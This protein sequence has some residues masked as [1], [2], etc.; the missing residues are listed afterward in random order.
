MP[1][2]IPPPSREW[3]ANEWLLPPRGKGRGSPGI[4]AEL[5]VSKR[6]VLG[7]LKFY[8]ITEPANV[9]RSAHRK[10]KATWSKDDERPDKEELAKLYLMPPDGKGKTLEWLTRHY[11]VSIVTIRKWLNYYDLTQPFHLR[12][13]KR[14]AGK[15][16]S[17]YV[18]GTSRAYHKRT[19]SKSGRPKECAWCKTTRRV[20]VH[21]IDHDTTNG[22]LSNLEWLCGTCNHLESNLWALQQEGLATVKVAEGKIEIT[23]LKE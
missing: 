9:R 2:K 1:A 5:G 16:N 12:H 23:F 7:W 8:G 18:N 19:L 4:A 10:G 21:H 17:S 13:S 11:Q 22:D 20:Q 6:T 15:G 3:L 14:M